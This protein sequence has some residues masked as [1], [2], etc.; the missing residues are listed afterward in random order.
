[1]KQI[2]NGTRFFLFYMKLLNIF[3]FA[4]VLSMTLLSTTACSNDDDDNIVSPTQAPLA[5]ELVGTFTGTVSVIDY[6]DEAI[7]ANIT[8]SKL[9][10]DAVILE[11]KF[12]DTSMNKIVMKV[13]K[14][15]DE[16]L[17]LKPE[18]SDLACYGAY[19]DGTLTFYWE[20]NREECVFVG[21]KNAE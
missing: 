16:G 3:T 5:D 20:S 19:K 1:M 13:S 18:I 7:E 17:K 15:S 11:L 10:S 21:K 9:T 8:L 6:P 12:S 14:N 2:R 4:I